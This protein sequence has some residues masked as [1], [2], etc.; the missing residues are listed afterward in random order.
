MMVSTTDSAFQHC[1]RFVRAPRAAYIYIYID[2]VAHLILCSGL[3]V[4]LALAH[5]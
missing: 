5:V 4:S 1:A 3:S 2:S